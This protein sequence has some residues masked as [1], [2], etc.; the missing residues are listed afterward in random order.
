[1]GGTRSLA[2][3]VSGSAEKALVPRVFLHTPAPASPGAPGAA[4]GVELGP[5]D[6]NARSV[7]LRVH[8]LHLV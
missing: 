8:I 1:M 6:D 2:L 4:P 7:L 5:G 3:L